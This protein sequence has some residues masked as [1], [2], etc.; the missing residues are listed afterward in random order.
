M[1]RADQLLKEPLPLGRIDPALVRMREQIG[2][3]HQALLALCIRLFRQGFF[4]C[5]RQCANPV[6][7]RFD[8]IL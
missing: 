7:Q 5:I 1:D 8:C 6:H 4:L 2:V 3:A